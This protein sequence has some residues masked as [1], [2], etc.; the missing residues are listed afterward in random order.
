MTAANFPLAQA[1]LKK[2]GSDHPQY[3]EIRK[4]L[5]SEAPTGLQLLLS[6]EER[7]RRASNFEKELLPALKPGVFS[8][9]LLLAPAQLVFD[10]K[11]FSEELWRAW[12]L[13][14]T[15]RTPDDPD[16]FTLRIGTL[17]GSI[18]LIHERLNSTSLAT[19]ARK[20]PFTRSA[21]TLLLCH[22]GYF[23]V[24]LRGNPTEAVEA[25][26]FFAQ[27]LAALCRTAE[28]LGVFALESLQKPGFYIEAAQPAK[29][30]QM[31]ILSVIR[32]GVSTDFGE[33]YIATYG[34][35]AFSQPELEVDL[36]SFPTQA[37][38]MLTFGIIERILAGHF[39]TEASSVRFGVDQDNLE[40]RNILRAPGRVVEGEALRL[41]LP[42]EPTNDSEL[43][44]A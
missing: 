2:Y 22:A 29:H 40:Q 11:L 15:D 12:N 21:E 8:A 20:S 7:V 9:E 10:K 41:V 27:I 31:P 17:E 18:R 24:E 13:A 3:Q 43:P 32:A 28:P 35:G 16:C 4:A 5:E 33:D 14:V 34:L 26:T 44:Q 23:A 25:A 6:E 39:T 19:A 37:G 1:L 36:G 42:G 38:A 30:G